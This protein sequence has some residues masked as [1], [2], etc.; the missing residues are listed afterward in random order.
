MIPVRLY[1][2][3]AAGLAILAGLGLFIHYQRS[4]GGDVERAK[5]VKENAQFKVKAD[6][7][8]VDYDVCFDAGGLYDFRQGTCKLP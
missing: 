6:R 5:Q 2:Y 3:I 4:V 1:L 8:I 7:G